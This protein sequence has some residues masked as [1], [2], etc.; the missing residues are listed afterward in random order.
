MAETKQELLCHKV[1]VTEEQ[2]RSLADEMRVLAQPQ[3]LMI[4][5]LLR[6]QRCMVADIE[7]LTG[8]TQ[9]MLSQYLGQLRRAEL[10]VSERVGRKIFYRLAQTITAQKAQDLLAILVPETSLDSAS[11]EE[12]SASSE[13][14]PSYG[15]GAMFAQLL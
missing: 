1:P 4:L 15:H 12:K 7:R 11:D 10:V 6:Q 8:I 14:W 5:L 9:P 2:C 3:R 13:E